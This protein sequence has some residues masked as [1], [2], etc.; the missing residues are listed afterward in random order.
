MTD[1]VATYF[2]QW[3]DRT[4]KQAA[5]E[6]EIK[7]WEAERETTFVAIKTVP[8]ISLAG[9]LAKLEMA[10]EYSVGHPEDP[11]R[12]FYEAALTDLKRIITEGEGGAGDTNNCP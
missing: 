1:P 4:T 3:R 11:P 5:A 6:A 2:A 8:A 12:C 7:R 10:V 9:V